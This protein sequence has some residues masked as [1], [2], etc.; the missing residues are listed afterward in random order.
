[1]SSSTFSYFFPNHAAERQTTFSYLDKSDH[2]IGED[3]F[4]LINMGYFVGC[5]IWGLL[6]YQDVQSPSKLKDE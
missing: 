4:E 1:M 5:G 2:E 3:F 6:L